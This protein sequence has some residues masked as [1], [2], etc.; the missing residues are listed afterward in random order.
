LLDPTADDA[1]RPF[2]ANPGDFAP[3]ARLLLDDVEH[4]IAEGAHQLLR[5]DR[6]DAADHAGAEILLNPFGRRGTI[7]FR[8]ASLNWTPW[9]RS[10]TQVPLAWTN[11]G[12][13][14][15]RDRGR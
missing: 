2:R 3:P 6:P 14:S 12:R 15:P 7:A 5:V 4:G 13:L 8:N 1:L 10:L 9:V 11:C